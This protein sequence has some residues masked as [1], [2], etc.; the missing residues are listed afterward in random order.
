MPTQHQLA[1]HPD[2]VK[3]IGMI[4]LETVDLELELAILF[5]SMLHI[6]R[7]IGEAI[8]MS[9][10][11]DQARLDMMRNAAHVAFDSNAKKDPKSEL[12]Q[13]K[14]DALKKVLALIKRAQ[15]AIT[16]RH[17]TMHD[18]WKVE[19][20]FKD[21]SRIMIDGKLDRPPT[22]VPLEDLKREIRTLRALIDDITALAN[23]FRKK[24]PLLVSMRR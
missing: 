18:E 23:Q 4:A 24:P 7:K 21:I 6:S 1:R 14:K 12:E 9:P 13:Q 3:A 20:E 8:Y 2:H 15:T 5:S 22:L 10:R 16:Y 19:G 17:R 11:G